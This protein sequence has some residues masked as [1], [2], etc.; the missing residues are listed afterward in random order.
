MCVFGGSDAVILD[1]VLIRR[2]IVGSI[3]VSGEKVQISHI[4]MVVASLVVFKK[5][6][7]TFLLNV[8]APG[9]LSTSDCQNGKQKFNRTNHTLL[10]GLYTVHE[11]GGSLS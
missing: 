1:F 6:Q 5:E 8:D 7:V 4:L 10:Y 3:L 11:T 9:I 2:H